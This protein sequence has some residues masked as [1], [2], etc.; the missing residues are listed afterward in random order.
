[1]KEK[2]Q[3]NYFIV[4]IGFIKISDL[5]TSMI[6]GYIRQKLHMHGHEREPLY[7]LVLTGMRPLS[8][9]FGALYRTFLR[10]TNNLRPHI[11]VA[12]LQKI[13]RGSSHRIIL[14]F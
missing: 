4:G 5:K 8:F 2:G 3:V 10:I 11:R 12:I 1:V 7:M 14:A 13:Q 6:S 9:A